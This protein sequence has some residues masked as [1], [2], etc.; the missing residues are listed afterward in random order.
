MVVNK[1]VE[2]SIPAKII[3]FLDLTECEFMSDEDQ[4]NLIDSF[5]EHEASRPFVPRRR[6]LRE[7]IPFLDNG[8]W[9]VIRSARSSNDEHDINSM[10]SDREKLYNK[11]S[12]ICSRVL[13]E[14]ECRLVELSSIVSPCYALPSSIN[15]PFE[16]CREFFVL[17]D[18]HEW[19]DKFLMD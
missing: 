5:H 16:E 2:D 6:R 12:K 1:S 17:E 10:L 19:Q 7:R 3:M 11:S 13:L 4:D 8:K 15:V 18:I 14:D 9:A